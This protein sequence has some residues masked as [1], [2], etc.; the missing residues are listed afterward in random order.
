LAL[1]FHL[2]QSIYLRI[3][4]SYDIIFN[5]IDINILISWKVIFHC[6][7]NHYATPQNFESFPKNQKPVF[8]NP[9][10]S[11]PKDHKPTKNFRMLQ[12]TYLLNLNKSPQK[13]NKYQ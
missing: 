2:I 13:S 7:Y 9:R 3:I 1:G 4:K 5:P 11:R 6:Y 8:R 10:I 12:V